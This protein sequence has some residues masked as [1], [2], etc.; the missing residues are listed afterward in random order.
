M[1][2]RGIGIRDI[3]VIEGLSIVKVL[4]VISGSCYTVKPKQHH[5]CSLEVDEFWTYAGAKKNKVWLIYAYD[6]ESGE[7]VSF[8]WGKRELKTARTLRK[9]SA[10]PESVMIRSVLIIGIALILLLNRIIT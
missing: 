2:V 6:R 9:N 8:V 10:L 3:S 1:T 7:I 5:Y 4:S